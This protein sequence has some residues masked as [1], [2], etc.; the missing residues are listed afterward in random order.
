MPT[1]RV[2]LGE[3]EVESFGVVL[4][5]PLLPPQAV[6]TSAPATRADARV[7]TRRKGCLLPWIRVK[8]TLDP[9]PNRPSFGRARRTLADPTA[10]PRPVAQSRCKPLPDREQR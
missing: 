3:L 9:R 2:L 5:P 4:L 1:L 10:E 7:V 8:I 6:R